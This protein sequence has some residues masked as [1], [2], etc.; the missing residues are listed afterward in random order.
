MAMSLD[1]PARDV[2]KL[3]HQT[4]IP[5][6]VFDPVW[7]LETQPEI[8]EALRGEQPSTLLAWHF[9]QGQKLGNSPNVFFDE[10]WHRRAYPAVD[11]MV[12]DGRVKSAF[13]SVPAAAAWRARRTG[14]S[15]NPTTASAIRTSPT[16]CCRRTSWPTAT[17]IS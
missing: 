4:A 1:L 3:E 11:S 14:C 7:Y 16:M 12:R 9:E 2:L 15:T 13:D 10:A 5:W 6:A 8:P 17:T